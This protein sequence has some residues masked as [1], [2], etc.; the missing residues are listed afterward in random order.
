MRQGDPVEVQ[1]IWAGGQEI[2]TDWFGGYTFDRREQSDVIVR[3]ESG[4]PI[5]YHERDVRMQTG[6]GMWRVRRAAETRAAIAEAES[7]FAEA[8]S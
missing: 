2:L 4:A 3:D 1:I 8:L 7:A 5:R 6:G